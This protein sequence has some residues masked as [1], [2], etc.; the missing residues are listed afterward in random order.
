MATPDWLLQVKC[1]PRLQSTCP[2]TFYHSPVCLYCCAMMSKGH[3][4][5]WTRVLSIAAV[6][7][8]ANA[9]V[10]RYL[11]MGSCCLVHNGVYIDPERRTHGVERM[12]ARKCFHKTRRWAFALFPSSR[13]AAGNL[14]RGCVLI[15]MDSLHVHGIH[16]VIQQYTVT[17]HILVQYTSINKDC[18]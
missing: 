6:F 18:D 13:K 10:G 12:M 16:L 11:E 3:R 5:N 4:G 8:I 7:L 9:I 2:K 15:I 17:I 14:V 1:N